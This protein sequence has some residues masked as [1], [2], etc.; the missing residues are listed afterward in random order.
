MSSTDGNAGRPTAL[1]T[2]ASGGIG[3]ELAEVFAAKGHDLVLVARTATKLEEVAKALREKHGAKVDVV[4]SDL[5]EQGAAA[6]LAK[7]LD[8]R[9]LVVDV[10]VNN[11]GYAQYGAFTQTDADA[12]SR[13][14][15]LNMVALTEL[16]KQLLPKMSE[17]GRGRILNVAST[18][19]FMPGPLMAVYY[20]T[21]AYVLSFSEALAEE[22]RGSG[23]S[24]TALCPG[25]TRTG[26]QDR[27][28]MQ[29]SKLVRGKEIMDAATVA[30]AGY[31]GLMR[32]EP[33]VIPG[34]MN[35][36]QAAT[37]RFLPRS[38]IPKIV[39]SAQARTG[40]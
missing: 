25:P 24:V 16:T 5:S 21:K 36:L 33:L 29:E 26:F 37:P 18:A 10:L 4:A 28:N 11:A 13:M 32:G 14:M 20:A 40:A 9:G 19:A 6:R 38:W 7:S 22:L 1:I 39:K 8:E 3:L 23:I 27:A 34:V 12:E 15:Q 35:R 31:E 2:G 30:R 17:R